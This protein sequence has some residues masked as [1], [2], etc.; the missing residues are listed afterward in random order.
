MPHYVLGGVRRGDAGVTLVGIRPLSDHDVATI[1]EAMRQLREF[2]ASQGL[3]LAFRA[4]LDALFTFWRDVQERFSRSGAFNEAIGHHVCVELT[5]HMMNFL[6]SYRSFL[7]C[8]KSRLRRLGR[9]TGERQLGAL[10][11]AR[12]AELGRRSFAFS[13]AWEFRN[14]VQHVG[15]PAFGLTFTSCGT[16]GAGCDAQGRSVSRP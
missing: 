16:A 3:Y 4:N 11:D 13:F 2:S 10:L 6:T 1:T 5:R 7:D 12:I 9:A 8:S 15:V 14:Y